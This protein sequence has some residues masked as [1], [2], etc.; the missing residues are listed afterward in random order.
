MDAINT[1][2]TKKTFKDNITRKRKFKE[3]LFLSK[4]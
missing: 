1:K 2:D 3:I 4:T